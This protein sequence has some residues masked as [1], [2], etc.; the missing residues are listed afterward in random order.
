MGKAN[1]KGAIMVYICLTADYEV[2]LGKNYSNID[3][4]L[5][6]PMN[7][8]GFMLEKK[9]VQTT[10]FVDILFFDY[11]LRHNEE[12]TFN[13]LKNN[14]CNMHKLG[15][16]IQVHIHPHW[17][18]T[19]GD[20]YFYSF[21]K[22]YYRLSN[23]A[24]EQEDIIRYSIN[25][26][27][28][29]IMSDYTNYSPIA[30]RAGGWSIQP[31]SKILET[32]FD[33]GVVVDS[34][35]VKNSFSGKGKIE[36]Y[37]YRNCP[38]SDFWSI[39]PYSHINTISTSQKKSIIEIPVYT[40]NGVGITFY[41]ILNAIKRRFMPHKRKN[42]KKGISCLGKKT[43]FQRFK[44]LLFEPIR[45]SLDNPE[46][47][48]LYLKT[49]KRLSKKR[50]NSIVCMYFHPKLLDDSAINEFEHFIDEAKRM[51]CCFVTPDF[52][53]KNIEKM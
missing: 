47:I 16:S 40:I 21:D 51:G 37:D 35:V 38:K 19:E 17:L 49:I 50:K 18:K 28:K 52:L 4:V 26:L 10:I 34:S 41:K 33:N 31:E 9:R 1:E 48:S 6:A 8:V 2:F 23:F 43:K 29:K 53:I 12:A 14:I 22:K 7:K 32:L 39:S 42:Q 27:K 24:D 25:F 5:V 36:F 46:H 15:H 13:S 11:L 20:L 30:F 45:F 3:E 44:S